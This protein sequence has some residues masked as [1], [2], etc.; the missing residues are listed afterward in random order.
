MGI[1][2]IVG[3]LEALNLRSLVISGGEPLLQQMELTL[4]LKIL[5]SLGYWV[6]IET[7][8]TVKPTEEFLTLVDQI[9]CSPKLS[10][11]GDPRK[12]RVRNESLAIL[13][14]SSKVYFKFVIGSETDLVEVEEY[15]RDFSMSSDRV[16]LMPL[17]MTREELALTTEKTRVLAEKYSLQFSSRRH[18]ELFGTKR[19][20]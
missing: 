11:C 15:I 16:Y 19:G 14:G 2:E 12:F 3:R 1:P 9:N 4:L 7:N 6:E 17:G 8:G 13:S 20:V 5:K 10:N 18:V